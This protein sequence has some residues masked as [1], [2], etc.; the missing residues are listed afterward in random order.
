[1]R[2]FEI[3]SNTVYQGGKN[4]GLVK[5]LGVTTEKYWIDHPCDPSGPSRK[6]Y[7]SHDFNHVFKLARNHSLD[8]ECAIPPLDES[9]DPLDT[10]VLPN[11]FKFTRNDFRDLIDKCKQREISIGYQLNDMLINCTSSD[12]QDMGLA[13]KLFSVEVANLLRR[14]YP[15]NPR[16][17]ALADY[18]ETMALSKLAHISI[19]MQKIIFILSRAVKFE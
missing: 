16:K 5:A 8:D 15:K 13:L 2:L 1:M 12:R 4:Q 17:L 3:F 18:L 7:F 10:V 14:F 19:F 6:I 11:G 9:F